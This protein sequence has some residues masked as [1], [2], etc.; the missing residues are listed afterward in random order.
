MTDLSSPQMGELPRRALINPVMPVK[1]AM[2]HDICWMQ[3]QRN[4]TLGLP[5]LEATGEIQL[6]RN[7][8][9]AIVGGGPSL[10]KTIEELRSFKGAIMA[11]G[12]AHD[13]L[14]ENGIPLNYCII[15][16]PDKTTALYLKRD[17][18]QCRYLVASHVAPQTLFALEGRNVYLFG[19]GGTFEKDKFNPLPIVTVGGRTV[20]TRG[21]GM[22]LGLGFRDF[23]LFGFDSCLDEDDVHAYENPEG[24]DF[25]SLVR[26]S[27]HNV[28]CNGRK[29]KCASYMI[30]QA[31]DFQKFLGQWNDTVTVEVHGDGLISE[32]M[33]AGEKPPQL[34]AV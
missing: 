16:D 30:G 21:M 34:E 25:D 14:V 19:A 2:G 20:G 33:K 8:P 23:H 1:M 27:T 6:A 15:L 9:I 29:F 3:H 17:G 26:Q 32:I 11:C 5:D 10:K 4:L 7:Y 12:S 18:G 22:A 24:D 13:Y 31:M 28:Y